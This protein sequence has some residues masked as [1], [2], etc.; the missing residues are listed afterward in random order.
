MPKILSLT[1]LDSI[2]SECAGREVNVYSME[3]FKL[4]VGRIRFLSRDTISDRWF[5][6]K[7]QVH[8]LLARSLA[9]TTRVRSFELQ[10]D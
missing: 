8:L 6:I 9:C 10:V 7:L 1:F 3:R 5:G 2:S 4:V